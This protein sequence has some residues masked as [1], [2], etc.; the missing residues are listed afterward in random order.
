[1]RR[2]RVRAWPLAPMR[3][4]ASDIKGTRPGADGVIPHAGSGDGAQR[5]TA[6]AGPASRAAGPK[7][8]SS[9][10]PRACRRRMPSR[11]HCGHMPRRLAR[12][13][14]PFRAGPRHVVRVSSG[15]RTM[16]G[17]VVVVRRRPR[18]LVNGSPTVLANIPAWDLHVRCSQACPST[19]C[20]HGADSDQTSL[21]ACFTTRGR[22]MQQKR[23]ARSGEDA[24]GPPRPWGSC[25]SVRGTHGNER[26]RSCAG[27]KRATAPRFA[28]LDRRFAGSQARA[29]P[30]GDRLRGGTMCQARILLAGRSTPRIGAQSHPHPALPSQ[31]A[32]D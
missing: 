3:G 21:R 23:C 27:P 5:C 19:T 18:R 8:M 29:R 12:C 4:R 14:A 17:A 16:P 28:G 30:L 26:L 22:Q 13:S 1:M 10:H 25:K 11:Y 32:C 2:A 7:D 20:P 31:A 24:P 15:P 9:M 6:R